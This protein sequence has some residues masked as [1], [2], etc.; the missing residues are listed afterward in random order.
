[1]D[2]ILVYAA[3]SFEQDLGF[4]MVYSDESKPPSAK[5]SIENS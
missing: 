1:M 5:N 3:T 2:Q 4:F